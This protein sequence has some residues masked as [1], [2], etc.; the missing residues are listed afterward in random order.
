MVKIMNGD[1][2]SYHTLDFI[3]AII[4][5]TQYYVPTTYIKVENYSILTYKRIQFHI[6]E[7][8]VQKYM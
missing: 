1:L 3:S 6:M 2:I 5:C 7:F 4:F 8:S